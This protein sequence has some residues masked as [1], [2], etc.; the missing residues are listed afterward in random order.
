MV[1]LGA[2]FLILRSRE[3]SYRADVVPLDG[4]GTAD[5]KSSGEVEVAESLSA[6]NGTVELALEGVLSSEASSCGGVE[7]EETNA[8]AFSI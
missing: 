4:S 1:L 8:G 3:F 2:S 7:V 5:G 6:D